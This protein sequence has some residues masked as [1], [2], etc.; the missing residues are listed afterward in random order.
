MIWFPFY[1]WGNTVKLSK[2]LRDPYLGCRLSGKVMFGKRGRQKSPGPGLCRSKTI[3]E[4]FALCNHQSWEAAY[5]GFA[6][7]TGTSRSTWSVGCGRGC[8]TSGNQRRREVGCDWPLRVLC[9]RVTII[10]TKM[11]LPWWLSGKESAYQ[12]SRHGFDS[13]SRKT[14]YAEEQLSLFAKT[15]EAV[16]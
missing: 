13:W 14:P 2:L 16:L 9:L 3:Q 8:R 4:E 11:G 7:S 10:N 1:W 15:A 6:P 5:T 12:C